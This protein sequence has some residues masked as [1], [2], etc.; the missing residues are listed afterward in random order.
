MWH[1]W[2]ME[3]VHS[4]YPG[5]RYHLEHIRV[6]S[7]KILKFIFKKSDGGMDYIALNQSRDKHE[8]L[9]NNVMYKRKKSPSTQLVSVISLIW[10]HAS[11]SL[12]H[13]QASSKH[14]Y[15]KLR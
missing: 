12:C 15:T 1:V 2:R 13:I 11:N 10:Q 3:E 4:E 5:G 14:T 7:S 9:V 6:E 8:A